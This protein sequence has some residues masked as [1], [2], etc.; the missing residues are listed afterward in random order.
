MAHR[1]FESLL[2]CHTLSFSTIAER[3]AKLEHAIP[4][5]KYFAR[6]HRVPALVWNASFH[7]ESLG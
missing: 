3:K 5:P 7:A 4:K 1:T 2:L 6:V